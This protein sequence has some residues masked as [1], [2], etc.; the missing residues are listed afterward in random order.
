MI[1][2]LA[3]E[4]GENFDEDAWNKKVYGADVIVVNTRSVPKG[5]VLVDGIVRALNSR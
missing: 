3:D 2:I 1:R 4:I 5:W